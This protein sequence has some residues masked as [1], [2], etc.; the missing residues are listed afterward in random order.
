MQQGSESEREIKERKRGV[1]VGQPEVTKVWN[2]AM[3]HLLG[4]H[5]NALGNKWC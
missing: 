5:R 4:Q 3:A 2:E 1:R